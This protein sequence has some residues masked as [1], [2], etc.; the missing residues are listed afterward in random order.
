MKIV[1]GAMNGV[2]LLGLMNGATSKCT[3]VTAAVAY[4]T[5]IPPSSGT[6]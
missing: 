5:Q 6:V 3:R 4:A 2:H 1:M